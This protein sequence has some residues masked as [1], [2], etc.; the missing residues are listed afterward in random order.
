MPASGF[1]AEVARRVAT[2]ALILPAL[3][4]AVVLGP[5]WLTVVLSAAAAVVGYAEIL[6][7]AH[8][9]GAWRLAI[10][11]FGLLAAAFHDVVR[12]GADPMAWPLGLVLLLASML[13]FA[14]DMERSVPAMAVAGLGAFYLGGLAGALGFLRVA[15]PAGEGAWRVLLLLATVM[16]ADTFAYFGGR[17]LG[18]HRLAPLVS[19]GKTWEGSACSLLGGALGAWLVA[20]IGLP[21]LPEPHALVLGPAVAAA[22]TLGDLVESL[23]KRWAGAKDSGTLFPGHGGM[24]DRLDS[25]LFGAAVLYYYFVLR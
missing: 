17:F 25:L 13:R 2:A 9:L 20:R 24:L 8:S 19:P 10:G 18:R 6:T 4:V 3:V 22:G 12:P 15:P 23:I 7:L 1:R 11:G 16:V 5:P 14:R 21:S